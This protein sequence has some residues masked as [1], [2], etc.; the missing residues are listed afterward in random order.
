MKFFLVLVLLSPVLALG[1]SYSSGRISAVRDAGVEI[2]A[3]GCERPSDVTEEP[4]QTVKPGVT[5]VRRSYRCPNAEMSVIQYEGRTI[6]YTLRVTGDKT[7]VADDIRTGMLAR[8]V[9]RIFG[10][11]ERERGELM[12]YHVRQGSGM[13]IVSFGHRG[14]RVTSIEWTF[15]LR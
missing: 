6:P 5:A 2:V 7:P 13:D 9:K 10:T 4:V 15:V 12:Q 11:P 8:D 14:G 1:Q 3:R